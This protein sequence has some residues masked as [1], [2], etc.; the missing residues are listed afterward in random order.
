MALPVPPVNP[1]VTV[2]DGYSYTQGPFIG[3]PNKIV[4]STD[5]QTGGFVPGTTIKAENLNYILNNH[6]EWIE[7]ND[8]VIRQ[9]DNRGELL[10]YVVPGNHSWTIPQNCRYIEATVVGGGGNGGTSSGNA[11][12]GGGSSGTWGTITFPIGTILTDGYTVDI[13]VGNRGDESNI[14]QDGYVKIVGQS[15]ANGRNCTLNGGSAGGRINGSS[16]T[17][18]SDNGQN[19]DGFDPDKDGMN[20]FYSGSGQSDGGGNTGGKGANTSQTSALVSADVYKGAPGGGGGAENQSGAIGNSGGDGGSYGPGYYIASNGSIVFLQGNGGGGGGG[21]GE[22]APDAGGYGG[23]GGGCG[24]L[25]GL[26]GER[27]A[28][29]YAGQGFGWGAGG[30][31]EGSASPTSAV[32][33]G[34]GGGGGGFTGYINLLTQN[35]QSSYSSSNKLGSQGLVLIRWW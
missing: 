16:T 6:A 20:Q 24:G 2:A 27:L 35:N 18:N 9:A 3:Q 34:G 28:K 19:A 12:A 26:G 4:P 7:Y 13:H 29:E 10:A 17:N 22:V 30:G 21:G 1:V 14:R 25:P 33:G 32:N 31:G 15:G 8:G 5:I 23:F 11:G